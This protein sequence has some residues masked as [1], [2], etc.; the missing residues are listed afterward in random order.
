LCQNHKKRF[1]FFNTET[2][3]ALCSQCIIT[4]DIQRSD[5]DKQI[6]RIEEAYS[7][8]AQE[9]NSDDLSLAEKKRLI[10][11][12]LE[13]VRIKMEAMATNA[14][15]EMQ[16]LRAVLDDALREIEFHV[17]A[18]AEQL[19][20]DRN[21]LT[22][23]LYE[24]LYAEVFI[25]KQS[26]LADPLEFLNMNTGFLQVKYHLLRQWPIVSGDLDTV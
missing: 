5:N 3:Q 21:E 8:A 17:K 10:T 16:R 24:I 20:S 15:K 18:K 9:A 4:G 6:L 7:N 2:C 22:R 1:E 11:N 19:K 12:K 26:E 14:R 23:Q 13:K 25:K